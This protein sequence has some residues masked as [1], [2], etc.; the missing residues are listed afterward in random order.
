MIALHKEKSKAMKMKPLYSDR[1]A[2]KD[3]FKDS[4]AWKIMTNSVASYENGTYPK[5]MSGKV[6][7]VEAGEWLCP[8]WKWK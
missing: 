7:P 5:G 3:E 4:A 6:F 2:E 1:E 8:W